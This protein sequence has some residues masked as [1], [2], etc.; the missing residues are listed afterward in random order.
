[1]KTFLHFNGGRK[2]PARVAMCASFLVGLALIT[3]TIATSAQDNATDKGRRDS[4]LK[5]LIRA[6]QP[7][8]PCF[9]NATAAKDVEAVARRGDIVN[10]PEPL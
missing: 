8:A 1:M 7:P 5:E 10:L 4:D 3:F 9:P 6:E 2:F